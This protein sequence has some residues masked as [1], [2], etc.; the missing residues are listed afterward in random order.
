MDRDFQH[1]SRHAGGC[2]RGGDEEESFD[3]EMR[4]NGEKDSGARGP[5]WEE[6]EYD[7]NDDCNDDEDEE[8]EDVPLRPG[9][10]KALLP[11]LTAKL[12]EQHGKDAAAMARMILD[13]CTRAESLDAMRFKRTRNDMIATWWK[14][15]R[16]QGTEA[17]QK[18]TRFSRTPTLRESTERIATLVGMKMEDGMRQHCLTSML[19]DEHLQ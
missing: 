14:P 11:I 19:P 16:K 17:N 6:E 2:A 13:R 9:E 18:A 8:D 4:Y 1:G 15:K 10:K 5:R 12:E 7:E 3:E